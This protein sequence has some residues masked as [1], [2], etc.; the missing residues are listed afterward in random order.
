MTASDDNFVRLFDLATGS[1]LMK[2]KAHKDYI[3][4]GVVSDSSDDLILTGSYDHT[5]KMIDTRTQKTVISVDHGEPIENVLLFPSCNMIV[6]CGGNSIKVWDV[7]KGGSLMRTMINHHKTVTS[8][9]FSHN[10]KYL[11]SAGL[12]RHVK[13]FDLLNYD[14]VHTIDYP[15][16]ILSMGLLVNIK[17]IPSF[18]FV[19]F[20]IYF[21]E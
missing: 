8:L 6:S 15:S 4:C 10:C 5:V 18:L 20:L 9:T 14:L 7:L 3:R 16:P 17:F 1:T 11:L 12:D 13:V 2:L 21:Y 19:A